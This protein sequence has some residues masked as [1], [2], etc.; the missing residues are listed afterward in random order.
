[1][2][3]LESKY[4][5]PLQVFSEISEN[6]IR[7]TEFLEDVKT[8]GT[9]Y[10]RLLDRLLSGL[11]I[12]HAE[13]VIMKEQLKNFEQCTD[14]HPFAFNKDKGLFYFDEQCYFIPDYN[15]FILTNE[16]LSNHYEE[17]IFD[18]G[19]VRVERIYYDV[20]DKNA[21][22]NAKKFMDTYLQKYVS[23]DAKISL[24]LKDGDSLVFKTQKINPY[25]INLDVMYNE[26]FLSVHQ[27]IKQS[28]TQEHKGVVLLH[29][30]AGSGKTNYIKWLTSQIPDKNFI[31]VSTAMIQS[32]V[33][34]SFMTLL[35]ENKNSVLVLEDC[36][37][38]I[39]ER[40][41]GNSN[42][43]VVTSIL[44]IADGMLSDV[45]E[46]QFICTF[47][48]DLTEIDHALLRRGRLIA[49]YHFKE[50]SVERCNA[51]LK[52]VG[53]DISVEHPYSLAELTHIDEQEFKAEKAQKMKIGFI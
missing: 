46:C 11:Y 7:V 28:L 26:D 36:E 39:A 23:P 50:L 27:K 19:M 13:L 17:S 30:I 47:N 16:D 42:T 1:M 41:S 33:E 51:Y 34:P 24:L 52:S 14:F 49:E 9:P 10:Q 8:S 38:Y 4:Y 44:N 20:A 3:L 53:K 22:P 31:F 2:K 43:D 25:S 32:L 35:L 18:A 15:I 12:G 37:N 21:M 29:G 40:Q 48:A 5:R 6:T 45:L